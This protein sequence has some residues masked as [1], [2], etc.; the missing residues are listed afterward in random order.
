MPT[1]NNRKAAMVV[2]D[3]TKARTTMTT[4]TTKNGTTR[5]NT[6]T[7]YRCGLQREGVEIRIVGTQEAVMDGRLA[8]TSRATHGT[9]VHDTIKTRVG[10][11]KTTTGGDTALGRRYDDRWRKKRPS[12]AGKA[13]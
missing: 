5:A 11:E 1:M 2:N 4:R 7:E 6:T 12:R 3:R 9:G 13:E 10:K 8:G